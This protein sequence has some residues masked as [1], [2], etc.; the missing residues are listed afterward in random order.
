MPSRAKFVNTSCKIVSISDRDRETKHFFVRLCTS[1]TFERDGRRR[2][3][4]IFDCMY[5]ESLMFWVFIAIPPEY[6]D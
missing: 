6:K 5:Y 1:V 2:G 3:R 4:N